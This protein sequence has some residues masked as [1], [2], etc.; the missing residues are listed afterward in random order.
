MVNIN[1]IGQLIDSMEEAAL[2]LEKSLEKRNNVESNKLRILIFD[3]YKKIDF[4]L[5]G[6]EKN[7]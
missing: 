1:F 2:K 7:V 5:T 4:E 3:L 6:G